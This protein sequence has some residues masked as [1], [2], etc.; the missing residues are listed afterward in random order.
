MITFISGVP[1]SGKTY[2]AVTIMKNDKN[3]ILTNIDIKKDI[4][5]CPFVWADYYKKI[6]RIFKY[7][8]NA[9]KAIKLAKRFNIYGVSI[10]Y[11]ECHLEL[12]KQN[13][14]VIWWLSWHRHISQTIYLIT[15]SK[16]TLAQVYRAYPEIFVDAHPATKRMFGSVMRYTEFASY[17]MGKDDVIRK[18]SIKIDSKIFEIYRTGASTKGTSSLRNKVYLILAFTAVPIVIFYFL[19]TRFT[20]DKKSDDNNQINHNTTLIQDLNQTKENVKN[21]IVAE[22]IGDY[23]SYEGWLFPINE[24]K[25]LHL[26]KVPH[27]SH[28]ISSDYIRLKFEEK[29]FSLFEKL[30]EIKSI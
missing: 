21:Y 3:R 25:I 11:D 28:K 5:V 8:E 22:I 2:Y 15:Q 30:L 19:F 16:G 7:K 26:L 9:D 24:P 23:F 20:P 1:G 10:Y 4:E 12:Q 6:S 14:I 13:K 17:K 27:M 18:F 29:Y